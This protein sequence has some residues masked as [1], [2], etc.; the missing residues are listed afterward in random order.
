MMGGGIDTGSA[1]ITL[2]MVV[3]NE[4]GRYLEK[5][6]ETNK[7]F[8]DACVIVDDASSDDTIALCESTLKDIPHTIIKNTTYLF[9]NEVR[10]RRKQWDE[11]VKRNPDW[12]L[13]LDADEELD[14]EFGELRKILDDASFESVYLRLY[15]MWSPEHYREDAWWR[16]HHFYRPFLIKYRPDFQYE[17]KEQPVHCGRFPKNI[18]QFSYTIHSARVKHW[19]WAK[20]EDREQ[21]YRR[22]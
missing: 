8:I 9:E 13:N 7:Q 11:T 2:S 6:L 10:L 1:N 12:I 3:R 16:A 17:W 20:P 15:D 22:Y 19:G 21:K 18:N 4:A 5:C 14:W